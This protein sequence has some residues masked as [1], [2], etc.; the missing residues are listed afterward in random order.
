MAAMTTAL[1]EFSTLGDSRTYTQSA[2]TA[3]KPKLVIQKRRVPQGNQSVA[4][5]TVSVINAT[6]DA[7]GEILDSKVVF[8]AT[9]RYPIEGVA[10]EVTAVLATFRDIIAGDEWGNTVTTQEYLV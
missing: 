5:T 7:N 9:A 6:E 1:T 10:S 8:T 2:H 4:E 3:S